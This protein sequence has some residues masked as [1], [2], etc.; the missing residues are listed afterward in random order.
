MSN[1]Y[2][3]LDADTY[4]ALEEEL[5]SLRQRVAELE[6]Q[7]INQHQVQ[8]RMMVESVNNYEIIMLDPEG[9]ILTWNEGAKLLKGYT[10]QEIIG[11]H[12][13]C[14]YSVEDINSGVDKLTLLKAIEQGRFEV[15]GWRFRKDGSQFWANVVTTALKDETG[16]LLGFSKM[17]RDVTDRRQVEQAQARLTTILEATTDLVGSCDPQGK[18]LYLNKA[19]RRILGIDVNQDSNYHVSMVHPEWA[20]KIIVE[21]GVPTAIRDGVWM[22]ETALLS[23]DGQEIPVS[24][25]LIAHKTADGELEFFST[26]ARDIS[27]IKQTEAT[28]Q[29]AMRQQKE[30]F[31]QTECS[32]QLLRGVIDATPDWIMVKN[33]DFRY[34]LTNKSLAEAIGRTPQTVIGKND[35]ELGFPPEQVF[36][37]PEAGIRGFRA[38]DE[39]VLAGEAIYNPFDVAT[40]ADGSVHIFDTQKLPMRDPEGNIFGVLAFCR[41]IT[42]RH[43]AEEALRQKTQQ[44]EAALKEIQATQAQLVQSEKMSSLGQL[45]AG[46]AHEVNNPINFIHGN[47]IHAKE[48]TES[49]INLVNLYAKHYPQPTA[50]IADEIEAI[51]FDFLVKDLPKLLSSMKVGAERI[52]QIVLSL[53]NFSRLDEAEQKSVDIHEGIDNTL[54]ILQHRLKEKVGRATIQIVKEYGNLPLI[55]CYAGQLNQVFM[56]IINNGLDALEDY[57]HQRSLEEIINNPSII[58]IT[59]E[60]IET[61]WVQVR[62]ADNGL[63]ITP[64]VQKRLFDPFFTTKSVGKGTGLGLSISY[65]IIVEKHKGDLQCISAPGKGSEF[66]IKIPIKQ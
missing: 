11:K 49:L 56:N 27:E 39:Q 14:F 17:T 65:Q 36:G 26:I 16:K 4:T 9:Y 22:G 47:I 6:Q 32:A 59:T 30:L 24:Q 13:S 58:K 23:H 44:L 31:E 51:E 37:N 19:G 43:Q 41:D 52:R 62:I 7:L 33:K 38:D 64:E 53:R 34:M 25:V 29:Q 61:N 45:V 3:N 12:F 5:K 48:Y 18:I 8:F 1:Q 60:V 46:I 50:E 63:G 42:E 57:N 21:Q 28:L 66:I 20:T 54:L 55:E 15:E 10:A 35:L 40:S 2:V